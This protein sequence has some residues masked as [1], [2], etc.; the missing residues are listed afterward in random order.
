MVEPVA[1]WTISMMGLVGHHA[2]S[3][4]WIVFKILFTFTDVVIEPTCVTHDLQ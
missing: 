4:G 2:G 1:G 3:L